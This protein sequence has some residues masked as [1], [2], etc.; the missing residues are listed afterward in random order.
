MAMEFQHHPQ[1]WEMEISIEKK[2]RRL[3]KPGNLP[4]ASTQPSLF[5]STPP[6]KMAFVEGSPPSLPWE[7]VTE[8]P[9]GDKMAH[10][11]RM[12]QS[13]EL[14]S[15]VHLCCLL[16]NAGELVSSLSV[17]EQQLPGWSQRL[18]G[19]KLTGISASLSN[20]RLPII[21]FNSQRGEFWW[22]QLSRGNTCLGHHY[23]CCWIHIYDTKTGLLGTVRNPR[24]PLVFSMVDTQHWNMYI[25][26]FIIYTYYI[27]IYMYI[28]R[29]YIWRKKKNNSN[30]IFNNWF[31]E[32]SHLRIPSKTQSPQISS[33]LNSCG[34]QGSIRFCW[35]YCYPHMGVS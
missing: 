26:V 32:S 22:Y 18:S 21:L 12:H 15:R 31:S 1:P 19:K 24:Q 35:V 28:Y 5:P 10:S 16:Q 11:G 8:T 33:A 3:A 13:W 29:M 23:F 25:C 27:Y 7:L 6:T 9:S 14:L 4:S 34:P 30:N 20:D 2:I 17:C